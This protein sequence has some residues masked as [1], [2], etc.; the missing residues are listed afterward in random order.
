MMLTNTLIRTSSRRILSTAS[1][2]AAKRTA[3]SQT[4]LKKGEAT[5]ARKAFLPLMAA[6][7]TVGG[8]GLTTL[9]RR[10][11]EMSGCGEV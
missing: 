3:L 4:L 7:A 1:S 2:R 9:N 11:E 8:L 6:A 10:E 5:D